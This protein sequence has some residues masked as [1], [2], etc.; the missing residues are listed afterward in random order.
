MWLGWGPEL[1]FFYNEA[2]AT[3]TLGPK[4]PWALGQPVYE[5]GVGRD[6]QDLIGP[7]IEHV[8]QTGEATWDEGLQ[9]F[10]ERSGYPEETYHTFSYSP[11]PGR[12]IGRDRRLVLCRDRRYRARDRGSQTGLAARFCGQPRA[13]R[14]RAPTVCSWP[15]SSACAVRLAI[16]RFR[17]AT[18]SK[19]T[20]SPARRVSLT[21]FAE[22][23]PEAAP[24]LLLDQAGFWPLRALFEQT[25]EVVVELD[26]ARDWPRGAWQRA[27]SRAIVLPIAR[28]GEGRPAGVF[29]AGLNPHRPLDDSLRSFVRAIRGPID[30]WAR[31]RGRLTEGRSKTSRRRWLRSIARRPRFSRM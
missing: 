29:I 2:Y 30:G 31:Q 15:S 13:E 23:Q 8:M 12:C 24:V 28:P 9:L 6:L 26:E 25:P 4:H 27:P 21:G 11:A 16:F 18:C 10:L 19:K 3:Q 5:R 17:S 1:S 22:T 20:A 7:R 14:T